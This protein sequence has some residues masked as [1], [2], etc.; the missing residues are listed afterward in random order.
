MKAKRS[1]PLQ[2][3]VLRDVNW[4]AI[5]ALRESMVKQVC[6]YMGAN[7]FAL[8]AIFAPQAQREPVKNM[9][10]AESHFTAP[11]VPAI[12]YQYQTDT[13]VAQG[14]PIQQYA[15]RHRSAKRDIF[16]LGMERESFAPPGNTVH[17]LASRIAMSVLK[18]DIFAVWDL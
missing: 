15:L 12:R 5:F 7:I 16:A 11:Q 3:F 17:S 8:Q 14:I 6:E 9:N 2:I 18:K 4:T 1:V 10:V 13:T